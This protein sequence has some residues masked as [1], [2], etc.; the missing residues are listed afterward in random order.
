MKIVSIKCARAAPPNPV[1]WTNA[2]V[3]MLV[4]L[5]CTCTTGVSAAALPAETAAMAPVAAPPATS[6]VDAAKKSTAV[7]V[8]HAQ[9]EQPRAYGYSVGDLLQQRIALGTSSAPFV[10]AELPRIGR[11]GSSLWRRRSEEQIDRR[12]QHWLAIEYQLINTPQSLSV[13]YL[14]VLKLR[15]KDGSAVLTVDRSPFSIGP[16][17]PPQP[18]EIAALPG[19]QPDQPPALL[20]V[21][22]LERRIRLA[23]RALILVLLA[24]A[25][26]IGWRHLR[27]GRHLPFARAM[28]DLQGSLRKMDTD[29]LAARRR[30]LHA[31]NDT[32]GEVV[33]PSSVDK[34]IT[35]APY[36]ATEREALERFV[37]ES[38][39][40]FFGGRPEQD[41]DG[42]G[43]LAQRLR[44]LERR[45]AA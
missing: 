5:A 7:P 15:A 1:S 32:A 11:I 30:L 3:S 25:S 35:R 14:P 20:S 10:L 33:R 18:Y 8:I 44:R 26:L 6:T 42:I 17:T 41:V 2:A 16:F 19:L 45:H 12:G 13:W 24:W 29:P 28:H 39:A 27:R 21:A 38:H 31:L 36:L 22:P 34:L 23:T 40:V 9:V 37:R 4:G 43:F